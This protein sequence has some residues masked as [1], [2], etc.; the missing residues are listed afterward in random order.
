LTSASWNDFWAMLPAEPGAALWD[1]SPELTA[2]RHLPL[3]RHHLDPLLPLVDVGCGSGRQTQWLARHFQR[4]IGL[5]I[6]EAAVTLAERTHPASNVSYRCADLLDQH[7]AAALHAELGDA[8]VYL[9]GVLHQ[10]APAERVTMLQT[11]E[12]FLGDSGHIFAQE[13]TERT[14]WYVKALLDNGEPLPKT[15]ELAAHFDFGARFAPA[16]HGE[17]RRLFERSGLA[18]V[19]EGDM[20]LHT[21]ENDSG[22]R[23]LELPTSYVVAR[24][25][26]HPHTRSSSARP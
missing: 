21:T 25:M 1:A 22:G 11:I 19:A 7:A 24:A 4:V 5:D 23:P 8:N 26:P 17:L 10:L 2:A 9:R 15:A 3:F 12:P 13:L 18:V 20:P 6:A 14:G 16:Q